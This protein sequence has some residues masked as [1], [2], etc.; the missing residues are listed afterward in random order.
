M[1]VLLFDSA[2]SRNGAFGPE[3]IR[4]LVTAFDDAWQRLQKCGVRIEAGRETEFAREWLAKSI[5][6]L[7]E[8]GERDP[9]L[10]P[11]PLSPRESVAQ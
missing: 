9:H 6:E 3:E 5:I 11:S 4:I 7:A 1:S 10:R 8:L 2:L